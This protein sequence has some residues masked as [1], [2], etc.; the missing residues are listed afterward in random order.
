MNQTSIQIDP[1]FEQFIPPLLPEELRQLEENILKDGAILNPLILWNGILVDGHNR[2]RIA[3]KHPEISYTT[4]ER[5]FPDR[6]A[7]LAWICRNQLGRRNLSKRQKQ[8]LIA[9]QYEAEK[10]QRGYANLNHRAED[11]R[12]IGMCQSG[13]TGTLDNTGERIAKEHRIGRTSVYRAVD[14]KNALDLAEEVSHGFREAVLSGAIKPTD[15]ELRTISK[16]NSEDLP[17]LVAQVKQPKEK[18]KRK[19][20]ASAE[21]VQKIGDDMLE[22]HG[23]G[24]PDDMIYELKDALKDLIFR[25]DTCLETYERY[26]KNP[27]TLPRIIALFNELQEYLDLIQTKNPMT[28]HP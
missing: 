14:F 26:C 12:F 24:T 6:Y 8:Y 21:L 3:R 18:V 15:K 23:E 2:Y 11:G 7:A 5:E 19:K 25:W 4:I 28:P 22:T 10:Q 13:T 16:A 27:E 9:Q 17:A 20:S 1:E